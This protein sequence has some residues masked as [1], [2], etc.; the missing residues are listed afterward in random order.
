MWPGLAGDMQGGKAACSTSGPPERQDV[1]C[2]FVTALVM[3]MMDMAVKHHGAPG[4]TWVR[5]S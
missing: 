3:G 5:Q 4:S 2:V 1:G